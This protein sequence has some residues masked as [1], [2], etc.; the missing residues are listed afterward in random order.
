MKR[1]ALIIILLILSIF[2]LSSCSKEHKHKLIYVD[3]KPATC[4]EQGIEPFY[5]CT[6]C[7]KSFYDKNGTEELTIAKR[8]PALGHDIET[9][10]TADESGHFHKCSRCSERFDYE[11][12][13]Y[14][15]ES[16]DYILPVECTI[17]G[18]LGS[19]ANFNG[20]LDE[21][22]YDYNKEVD[23]LAYKNKVNEIRTIIEDDKDK[24]D[25]E[26]KANY[27]AIIAGFDVLNE[28]SDHITLNQF[29]CD[30]RFYIDSSSEWSEK[31][32]EMDN[33]YS[34]FC[35]EYN[36]LFLS[37]LKSNY[38]ELYKEECDYDDD[39]I[40]DLIS[41]LDGYEDPELEAINSR[42]NVLEYNL[43]HLDLSE[44]EYKNEFLELRDLRNQKAQIFKFDNYYEY[45]YKK[46]Y[47]RS[48]STDQI[49]I[50]REYLLEY[51]LD[52][53]QTVIADYQSIQSRISNEYKEF[54]TRIDNTD[55]FN[56]Y[57]LLKLA[58]DYFKTLKDEENSIDFYKE[59]NEAFKDGRIFRGEVAYSFSTYID[60][61]EDDHHIM[62]FAKNSYNSSLFSFIHESGH[63]MFIEGT[64]ND[65][66]Y[67]ETHSQTN[68]ELF[69]AYLDSV[70]D[71]EEQDIFNMLLVSNF[72]EC[73]RTIYST[74]ISDEME[75]AIYKNYYSY[76]ELDTSMFEDG[77]EYSELDDLFNTV[78]AKYGVSSTY[79]SGYYDGYFADRS[80][81]EISYAVSL[82]PCMAI[83]ADAEINGYEGAK[84][85]YFNTY[86]Y[87]F[88]EEFM[89]SDEEVTYLDVLEYANYPSPFEEETYILL[90]DFYKGLIK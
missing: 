45:A 71:G 77:I 34:E 9:I 7:K 48:Y 22:P 62:Y 44:E 40:R 69:L 29:A 59:I 30:M 17:C 63:F 83:L 42:I 68:E 26:L 19:R 85:K 2:I 78:C 81:Y 76:S 88:D 35:I 80:C 39:D 47:G 43:Y 61:I 66:D 53:Y 20:Y 8:A 27:D 46:V 13:S 16:E 75:E 11:A 31:M 58:T 72:L 38:L 6:E 18:L 51:F 74:V 37:L 55:C 56:D 28:A 32:I 67:L 25:E 21:I 23:V 70:Y 89:D 10:Y 90:R 36:K 50:F 54:V 86:L 87:M 12:H 65:Y 64:F 57:D 3:A 15:T 41:Q 14:N 24:S 79:F 52:I 4:T 1:K 49:K 60:E 33:I 82:I 84:E 73:F 5:Y